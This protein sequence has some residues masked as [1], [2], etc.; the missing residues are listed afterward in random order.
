MV[1][2]DER[3]CQL[4]LNTGYQLNTPAAVR[5]PRGCGNGAELPA[6]KRNY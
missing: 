5:Y 2:S 3:E 6:I 1:P 4:M